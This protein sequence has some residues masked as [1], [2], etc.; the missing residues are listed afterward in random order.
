MS[1]LLPADF[2]IPIDESTQPLLDVTFQSLDLFSAVDSVHS[3]PT[4][5]RPPTSASEQ[6]YDVPGIQTYS[7]VAKFSVGEEKKEINLG[8]NYDVHF[9]TAFPCIPNPQMEVLQEPSD[10]KRSPHPAKLGDGGLVSM[11]G[12]LIHV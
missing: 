7:A 9:V 8:L 4:A 2:S 12:M 5:E 11:S 10:Q 1:S 3:T 6:S